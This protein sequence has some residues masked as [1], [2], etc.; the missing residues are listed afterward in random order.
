MFILQVFGLLM[1]LITT[2]PL[3][4]I[5]VTGCLVITNSLYTNIT[6][7]GYAFRKYTHTHY[8][9]RT[10]LLNRLTWTPVARLLLL[11]T[12]E[13]KNLNI[14]VHWY[15]T[16]FPIEICL[17]FMSPMRWWLK[18]FLACDLS[19]N[20]AAEIPAHLISCNHCYKRAV[21]P[22]TMFKDLFSVWITPIVFSFIKTMMWLSKLLSHV[23]ITTDNND[24]HESC[25]TMQSTASW[26]L[27]DFW[28]F[29][30]Y[31]YYAV[32]WL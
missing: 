15:L 23:N 2:S 30:I 14:P 32:T 7:A 24:S 25:H 20:L 19:I 26:L 16:C 11:Y 4:N 28:W 5:A 1:I 22:I 13:Q 18:W 27:T 17:Y 31:I 21:F 3:S 8:E 29:N 6:Q 9:Q 12:F 10:Q